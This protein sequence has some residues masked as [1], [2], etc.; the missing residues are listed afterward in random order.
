MR[1]LVV[2][3]RADVG[4]SGGAVEVEF[5]ETGSA[6]ARTW[7]LDGADS[8]EAVLDARSLAKLGTPVAGVNPGAKFDEKV[9]LGMDANGPALGGRAVLFVLAATAIRCREVDRSATKES[10]WTF[11]Q[12]SGPDDSRGR[13]GSLP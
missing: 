3:Q 9:F 12:G 11:P 5:V 10:A 8:C 4:D 6:I 1:F 7:A 2:L 13:S